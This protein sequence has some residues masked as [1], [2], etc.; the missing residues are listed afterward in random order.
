MVGVGKGAEAGILIRGAEILERARKLTTAVFDKTGTLTRGEPNVTDVVPLGAFSEADVL[1]LGAAVEIGSEHPLGEAIVRAAKHRNVVLPAITFQRISTQYEHV[2]GARAATV[3]SRFQVDSWAKT[4]DAEFL[5]GF[6][7][8]VASVH[9]HFNQTRDEMTRRIV[10]AMENPYV[11]II[12]HP[13]ARLIGKRGP[14]E[15]DMEAVLAA[16]TRTGTAMELNAFPDRL[17]LR[18]DHLRPINPTPYK[19]SVSEELYA[20]LHSLWMQQTPI[21]VVR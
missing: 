12:G 21:D 3:H 18:D 15:F 10:R 7:L 13:T 8:C 19:V 9:S 5:A 16:A 1:R 17:D 11:N 6:D 20:Y 2:M 14:V 4:Y